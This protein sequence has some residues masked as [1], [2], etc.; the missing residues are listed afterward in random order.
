MKLN[1][2]LVGSYWYWEWEQL[3]NA[4]I[5]VPVQNLSDPYGS[6]TILSGSCEPSRAHTCKHIRCPTSPAHEKMPV[7]RA[8]HP[9]S[10]RCVCMYMGEPRGLPVWYDGMLPWKE[11]GWEGGAVKWKTEQLPCPVVAGSDRCIHG[12]ASRELCSIM[13]LNVW[14]KPRKKSPSIG[15]CFIGREHSSC[16]RH[17]T[18]ISLPATCLPC[19]ASEARFCVFMASCPQS[20]ETVFWLQCHNAWLQLLWSFVWI[21]QDK[22]AVMSKVVHLEVGMNIY[23]TL[24]V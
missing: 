10:S 20:S 24:S 6:S 22:A 3:F 21:P 7:V 16:V 2:A 5:T 1:K 9:C 11:R 8:F 18:K 19:S 23:N 15:H 14:G 13:A 12:P 4:W 17:S